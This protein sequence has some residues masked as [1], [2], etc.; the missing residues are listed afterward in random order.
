MGIGACVRAGLA[1]IDTQHYGIIRVCVL[2]S[3]LVPGEMVACKY[4][5]ILCIYRRVPGRERRSGRRGEGDLGTRLNKFI[6]NASVY[7]SFMN[8]ASFSILLLV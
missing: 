2:G 1:P 8:F 7:Y 4:I 3:D 5:V 6:R